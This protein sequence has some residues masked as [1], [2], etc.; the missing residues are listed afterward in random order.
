MLWGSAANVVDVWYTLGRPPPPHLTHSDASFRQVVKMLSEKELDRYEAF[1]R[2]SL[3]KPMQQI[4][5]VVT[6]MYPKP[7]DKALVALASVAKSLVG[8]LV[9]TG[10]CTREKSQVQA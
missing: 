5:H 4:M 2:S 10:A 6:G 7:Q 3:K 1:R 9:E 8:E